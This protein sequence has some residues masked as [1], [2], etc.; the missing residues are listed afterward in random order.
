MDTSPNYLSTLSNNRQKRPS[1]INSFRSTTKQASSSSSS[2]TS[3]S[4]FKYLPSSHLIQT[5]PLPGRTPLLEQT[6]NIINS[7]STHHIPGPTDVSDPFDFSKDITQE[8]IFNVAAPVSLD[9]EVLEFDDL[10]QN[11]THSNP[12]GSFG[13][14]DLN[15]KPDSLGDDIFGLGSFGDVFITQEDLVSL[16]FIL[17]FPSLSPYIYICVCISL[18]FVLF[19]FFFFLFFFF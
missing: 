16:L 17:N 11:L 9:F 2:S 3:S 14:S 8:N 13:T 5:S 19:F 1:L 10:P 4:T 12:V 6:S 18:I 7:P 15:L